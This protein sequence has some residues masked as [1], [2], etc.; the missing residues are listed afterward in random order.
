MNQLFRDDETMPPSVAHRHE[1]MPSEYPGKLVPW[2]APTPPDLTGSDT[3]YNTGRLRTCAY[4][5][6]VHPS[7]L[8]TWL[9]QGAGVHWSDWKYGW[10]H[11]V[12]VDRIPNPF[13]G[14]AESTQ[15]Q[16]TRP[17]QVEVDKGMWVQKLAYYLAS[18]DPVYWW[19]KVG[20][21]QPTTNG[22]FY[23]VHLQDATPEEKAVIER[24]MGLTFA[25]NAKGGVGWRAAPPP[26]QATI[27]AA[28][29]LSVAAEGPPAGMSVVAANVPGVGPTVTL[30][31]GVLPGE[32][33]SSGRPQ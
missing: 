18:G 13:A 28:E 4:C 5:G 21:A 30:T 11:K 3:T 26:V 33:P 29:G 10:P 12:Y 15:M 19:C 17:D 20:A 22:K 6:S 24:A 14:M 25:F 31:M 23:T 9:V 32:P 16:S 2:R 8:A 1:Y 27:S 7:D